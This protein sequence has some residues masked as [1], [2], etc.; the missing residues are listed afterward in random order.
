MWGGLTRIPRVQQLLQNFF[1][2]KELCKSINSDETVAYGAA[3]QAAILSGKGN[4]KV[5][6]LLLLDV[7]PISLGIETASGVMTVLILR[8]TTIRT[9]KEQIFSTYSNNQPGVLV[10]VYE[11]ERAQTKDNNLLE[12]FELT[13][14][15][16]APRGLSQ[17]NMCFDVDANGILNVLTEDKTAG[18]ENKIAITNDKC[19]LS[20]NEIERMVKEVKKYKSKDDEVKRK[21]EVS[22][23]MPSRT[24][25]TT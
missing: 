2:G 10:Q 3:V 20:K 16:L 17:I 12:N 24:T 8:N 25:H 14:I 13:G 19:R 4:E 21:V 6:G 22:L 18:V 1:N 5:Q 15:P 11:G 23:R 9:K 7:T